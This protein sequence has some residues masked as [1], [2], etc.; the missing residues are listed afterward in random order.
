M[1]DKKMLDVPNAPRDLCVSCPSST[2]KL[3]L[4]FCIISWTTSKKT[5]YPSPPH[6]NTLC[7]IP[8]GTKISSL[9]V[10]PH[11]TSVTLSFLIPLAFYLLMWQVCLQLSLLSWNPQST[12]LPRCLIHHKIVHVDDSAGRLGD[13]RLR[14]LPVAQP[15]DTGV[16]DRVQWEHATPWCWIPAAMA[17]QT[18]AKFALNPGGK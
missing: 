12:N 15:W 2:P 13:A 16:R 6:Q 1:K 18:Q 4:C 7:P 17:S 5:P 14:G 9:P 3:H 11:F 8:A 10:S